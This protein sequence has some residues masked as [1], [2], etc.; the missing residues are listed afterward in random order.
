[1]TQNDA[2]PNASL[3]LFYSTPVLLRSQDHRN[4]GLRK[5]G[6]L[7]FAAGAAAIPLT[8]GEFAAAGRH[9]P[10]VFSSDEGAMP[11]VVTGLD[12]GRNLFVTAEGTW[13]PGRY[14]PAYL[15]RYPFIS[16]ETEVGGPK[17]LGLDAA[18]DL[19]SSNA[20][21][22][23]AEPFFDVQGGPTDQARAAMAFC[24]AYGNEHDRTRTFAAALQEHNLLVTKSAEVTYA[25]AGKALVTG[26]RVI[27]EAAFRALSK[28]VIAA[29]HA[30]SW[31]DLIVLHLASQL[32]WQGLIDL[33]AQ[34]RSGTA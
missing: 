2:P 28:E 26:F 19:V 8:V 6:T 1:M 5:G 4:F 21:A 17:M 23:G 7:R 9:Y 34:S 11:L 18:S 16:I 22:D 13:V 14:V 32:S 3:P 25:D 31:L 20:S 24:D 15:R 10:I 29:F 12:A 30:N 33:A 27:E